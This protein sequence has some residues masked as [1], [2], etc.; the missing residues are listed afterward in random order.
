VFAEIVRRVGVHQAT[1]AAREER[2]KPCHYQGFR[3][4]RERLS[5]V[6]K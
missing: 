1:A 4:T 5:A 2:Q 3:H 6:A